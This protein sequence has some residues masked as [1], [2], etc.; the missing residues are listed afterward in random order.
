MCAL[1]ENS[2]VH[3]E[4]QQTQLGNRIADVLYLDSKTISI[5]FSNLN[6]YPYLCEQ[7]SVAS[8]QLMK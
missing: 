8:S 5:S 7:N 2:D 3:V 4:S 6:Q 1:N